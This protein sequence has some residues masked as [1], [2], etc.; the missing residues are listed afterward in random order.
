[1]TTY[2]DRAS[3][4]DLTT[5]ADRVRRSVEAVIEGKPEIVRLSL[6]VLLAE[7][8]LLIEDVPGVGKTMLAKALAQSIDCSVRRIQFTPDLLPSDITG[9]S[10]FDQQQRDF[11]F[12]PGAVFAQI[13]IGDEINRASPKTQSALL[14]SMA[15]RQVTVDGRTYELPSPFMVVATQ[16]PLE[17]EGTYPLPEAQR[18]R[19][20]ARVSIGYPSPDAEL[21]M[22]DVH[23]AVSP[24]DDLQPVAHAHDV[25]KLI[26]TVRQV[27]VAEPVRRYAVELVSATRNHPDIRLGASPR[28]TLHLLRAAKA[29]AALSGREYALPDDVR[30]LAVPVLAHRLLPTAQ[31]Q[32]NR[33]TADQVVLEILHRTPVPAAGPG[34][35]APSLHGRQPGARRL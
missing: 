6:T 20:M 17:M 1:M 3:L 7:G 27:H 5:T 10:V 25:L 16:N 31:T 28:A 18:D 14:E 29:T 23:G 24:L 4:T 9:V 15:E 26:D 35:P 11:E 33:R 34:Q 8:H 30:S 12:K 21:R 22:L 19:F 13:V 2:D 32:L